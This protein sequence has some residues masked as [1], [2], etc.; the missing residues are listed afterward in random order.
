MEV[1]VVSE[2]YAVMLPAKVCQHLGIRP[3]QQMAVFVDGGRMVMMPINVPDEPRGF[4]HGIDTS[5][6]RDPDR[7]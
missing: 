5:V 7:L 4:L 6:D 1:A 3:G 2:D